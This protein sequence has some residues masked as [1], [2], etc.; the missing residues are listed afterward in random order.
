M[1]ELGAANIQEWEVGV[2]LSRIRLLYWWC[3]ALGTDSGPLIIQGLSRWCSQPVSGGKAYSAHPY[4][5]WNRLFTILAIGLGICTVVLA[6]LQGMARTAGGTGSPEQ[7]S[8]QKCFISFQSTFPLQ[9][10]QAVAYTLVHGT[11]LAKLHSPRT[12]NL[13]WRAPILF[14]DHQQHVKGV[15]EYLIMPR[16]ASLASCQEPGCCKGQKLQ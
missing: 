8:G 7:S 13:F 4:S 16:Q 12:R 11:R 3:L 6:M 5:C 15:G 10:G 14:H 2:G 9:V 1:A